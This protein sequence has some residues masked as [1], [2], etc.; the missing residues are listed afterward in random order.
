MPSVA[1]RE[2]NRR[3]KERVLAGL[4]AEF[5]SP[6]HQRAVAYLEKQRG[7]SAKSNRKA[8]HEDDQLREAKKETCRLRAYYTDSSDK[9]LTAIR[10]LFQ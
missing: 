7:Y 1:K 5:G 2:G 4:H 8:Y 10:R 9:F 6:E 3:Y